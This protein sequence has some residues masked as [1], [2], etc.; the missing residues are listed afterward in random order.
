[1][2]I[3]GAL[4]HVNGAIS[5]EEFVGLV[6]GQVP[7]VHFFMVQPPPGIAMT[8]AIDWRIVVEDMTT[9]IAIA[10]ALW[11]G[12]V[13]RV[14]PLQQGRGTS[15]AGLF[16]QMRH[17]KGEFDQFLIGRDI[18]DGEALVRRMEETAKILCPKN[19]AEAFR[20]EMEETAQSGFWEPI[21][22]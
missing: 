13:E 18:T 3:Q 7:G 6:A 5:T 12:Y 21:D 15:S 8:A 14:K 2:I 19:I 1:M 16:V 9:V 4:T 10:T 22:L 20:R 11:S 17:A